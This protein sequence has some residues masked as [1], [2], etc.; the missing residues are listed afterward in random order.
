[1]ERSLSIRTAIKIKLIN[2]IDYF[3]T[4]QFLLANAINAIKNYEYIVL[5][6]AC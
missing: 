3:G 1:M 2:Q 5:L 4:Y 6:A